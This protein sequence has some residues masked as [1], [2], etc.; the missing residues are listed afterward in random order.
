M[1]YG[2]LVA[3]PGPAAFLE[4]SRRYR[5]SRYSHAGLDCYLRLEEGDSLTLRRG[6]TSVLTVEGAALFGAVGPAFWFMDF[7][8]GHREGDADVLKRMQAA[9]DGG[10]ASP[11]KLAPGTVLEIN[12][13]YK[14]EPG[15]VP[16][17]ARRIRGM[18]QRE[19]LAEA[20]SDFQTLMRQ[21]A[22]SKDA[23]N[24]EERW[25][26]GKISQAMGHFAFEAL[27]SEEIDAAIQ[28]IGYYWGAE[29]ERSEAMIDFL[30]RLQGE[31][32]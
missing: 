12:R 24:I 6:G 9:I 20:K 7:L 15:R 19:V 32:T 26:A 2:Y 17:V 27:Q 22:Q 21:V 25:V 30:S 28:L 16:G 18:K 29:E 31:R 13:A 14:V 11:L 23:I 5:F 8:L 3:T 10:R 4:K 1:S